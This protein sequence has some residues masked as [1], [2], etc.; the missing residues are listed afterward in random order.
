M[1]CFLLF[2]PKD[3]QSKMTN[4]I[5]HPVQPKKNN[6]LAKFKNSSDRRDSNLYFDMKKNN[7]KIII[8]GTRTVG[9]L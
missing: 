3:G 2:S 4:K 5:G 6:F 1:G 9:K 8:D 7:C